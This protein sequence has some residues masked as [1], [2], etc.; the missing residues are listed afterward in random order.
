[1]ADISI[2]TREKKSPGEQLKARA[3]PTRTKRTEPTPQERT[4]QRSHA[5]GI[6]NATNQSNA[7][8]DQVTPQ[9]ATRRH[10]RTKVIDDAMNQETVC[11]EARGGK[12]V[13]SGAGYSLSITN[14]NGK[15]SA[16]SWI[17][18][19]LIHIETIKS[20]VEAVFSTQR[21]QAPA[22][23]AAKRPSP[24]NQKKSPVA[25]HTPLEEIE[26]L[27]FPLAKFPWKIG[28]GYLRHSSWAERR[29][30]P[31]RDAVPLDISSWKQHQWYKDNEAQLIPDLDCL[32]ETLM[33]QD[34]RTILSHIAIML[35][36]HCGPESDVCYFR[37]TMRVSGCHVLLKF[38]CRIPDHKHARRAISLQRLIII[39]MGLMQAK[40]Q[41]R[42]WLPG[43]GD[44]SQFMSFRDRVVP[45]SFTLVRRTEFSQ[46]GSGGCQRAIVRGDR[47]VCLDIPKVHGEPKYII[48]GKPVNIAR[49]LPIEIT[50]DL[51]N[52][53]K[54]DLHRFL[55]SSVNVTGRSVASHHW[56]DDVPDFLDEE[57]GEVKGGNAGRGARPGGMAAATE[58]S[59]DDASDEEPILGPVRRTGQR[60]RSKGAI[61]AA[62]NDTSNVHEAEELGVER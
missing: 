2:A 3:G 20:C 49:I 46:Q 8:R 7:Q 61:G 41:L 59:R 10:P 13:D 52:L 50:L 30:Q 37:K 28:A 12:A 24:Q 43:H 31:A 56:D 38:R 25:Q 33:K 19:P 45:P 35:E 39:A 32:V 62:K 42:L 6:D 47:P 1:M 26:V 27:K 54:N 51:V 9:D 53:K 23:K 17:N 4:Q 44:C 11:I 57:T 40:K 15:T 60:T 29:F 18:L 58:D 5:H 36:A 48:V 21:N 16:P 22:S 55:G 34:L 14:V